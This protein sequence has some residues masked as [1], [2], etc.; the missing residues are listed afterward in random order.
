VVRAGALRGEL[1]LTQNHPEWIFG[2]ANGGLL[3]LGHPEALKW[4][5]EHFDTLIKEQGV[6]LYREDFN[7]DPL[8]YW[9]G[10]DTP[11]RQGMTRTSTCRDTS[12]SGMSCGAGIRTC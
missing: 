7:I 3:N 2:G 12:R 11:D 5:I 4:V 10:N 9:R 1:L 6:D 8:G